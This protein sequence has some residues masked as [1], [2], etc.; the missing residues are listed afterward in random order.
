MR[1][2]CERYETNS[3]ENY[4]VTEDLLMTAHLGSPPP[5]AIAS[6]KCSCLPILRKSQTI[7]PVTMLALTILSLP[8]SAPFRHAS[9]YRLWSS[10][11]RLHLVVPLDSLLVARWHPGPCSAGPCRSLGRPSLRPHRLHGPVSPR[12][13]FLSLRRFPPPTSGLRRLDVVISNARIFGIGDRLIVVR[14]GV[15]GDDVPSM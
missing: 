14:F 15:L 11:S 12:L 1:F 6:H 9:C 5:H 2:A 10:F 3:F 7:L 4:C 13:Y 8:H